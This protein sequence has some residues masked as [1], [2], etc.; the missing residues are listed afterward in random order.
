MVFPAPWWFSRVGFPKVWFGK[1]QNAQEVAVSKCGFLGPIPVLLH[2]IL[3]SVA[4][5]SACLAN[6]LP[7]LLHTQV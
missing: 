2:L 3:W 4:Q 6:V 5:E 1:D 7:A